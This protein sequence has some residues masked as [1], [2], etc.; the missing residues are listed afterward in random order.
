MLFEKKE[1]IAIQT[2]VVNF[3]AHFKIIILKKI[4]NQNT[5]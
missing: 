1:F 5:A 4:K 2:V 3:N